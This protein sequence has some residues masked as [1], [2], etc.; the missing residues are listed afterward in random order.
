MFRDRTD[1][2]QQLSQRL[3][4]YRGQHPLVVAIPRG[5]LPIAHILAATLEGDLDVVLVHKL[6]APFEPEV[7]IGAI[8]ETGR[9]WLAPHANAMG[10]TPTYVQA[11]RQ[12]QLQVLHDRRLR[13][14]AIHSPISATGRLVIV[15]DDGLAT[16]ATM[17]AALQ[18]LRARQPARLVCASPVASNSAL[19]SVRP[20]ADEVVCLSVP[21]DFRGVGQFY[22]R[23]EQVSDDEVIALLHQRPL[24]S[25]SAVVPAS[26]ANTSAWDNKRPAAS[27][28]ASKGATSKG[29]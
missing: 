24:F 15:V 26:Q 29:H 2:A 9:T 28:A 10:A 4:H 22:E 25:D 3:R 27:L 6:R 23:F 18:A 7:A 19:A 14:S 1:A 5:A 8:D 11:E 13:C 16:G 12:R 17:L 21:T 20:L